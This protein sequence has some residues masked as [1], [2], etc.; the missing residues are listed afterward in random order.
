MIGDICK[1]EGCTRLITCYGRFCQHHRHLKTYYGSYTAIPNRHLSRQ[2][3]FESK[4]KKDTQTDCI[5][6]MGRLDRLGYGVL[7]DGK[8]QVKAHRFSWILHH[9]EIP[10]DKKVLHKCDVRNCVNVNHLFIGTQQDNIADMHNKNRAKMP[11]IKLNE[12]KVSEIK[13]LILNNYSDA[14]I[15]NIYGVHKDTIR[16]I[17]NKKNWRNVK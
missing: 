2:D 17:R 6:W 11:Y 8:K 7:W 4:L 5:L 12:T 15:A 13:K 10:G 14:D 16:S 3:F 9:K 1:I